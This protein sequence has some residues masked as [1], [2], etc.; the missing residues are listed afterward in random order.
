MKKSIA[1]I[2]GGPSSLMLAAM[3]DTDKFDVTIYERKSALARKFLVAGKGGFNLT[4]SEETSLLINRYTPSGFFSGIIPAFTSQDLRNW[5]AHIGI[6]TYIGTSNRVFPVKGTKPIQVLNAFLK[7]LNQKKIH[8]KSRHEWQGWTNDQQLILNHQQKQLFIK[9]DFTVFAMGGG[10]WKITGSD[11]SWISYFN[12]QHIH[13]IPFQAS[14]CGYKVLWPPHFLERTEGKYLKNIC[15]RCAGNERKGE[16]VI[17]KSGLEGSA[18]YAM[19]VPIRK[20][21]AEHKKAI[22]LLDL[23]PQLSIESIKNKLKHKGN[24]SLSKHLQDTLNINDV[25]LALIHFALKKEEFTDMN[26]LALKLKQ[27]P[28]TIIDSAPIDEAISTAGGIDLNEI[29]NHFE[30]KKLPN[31]FA[32]GEM[33]NWEAPTGGYLL[34]ACF[35]MGHQLAQYFNS[36]K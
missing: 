33:L 12:D 5:L 13:T 36:Y 11:G 35:S 2:G 27:L 22:V 28:I 26:V 9:T 31:H 32:I 4:H 24:K 3:L 18:I 25:Q 14:N 30:L 21:L 34:Q 8:I 29:D 16:L 15:I 7:K 1:I 23:K 17:T 10:S 19:S 6:E 20:Q